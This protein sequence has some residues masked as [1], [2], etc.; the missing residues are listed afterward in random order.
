M[1]GIAGRFSFRQAG[2][3]VSLLPRMIGLLAHR[4]PDDSGCYE[5]NEAGLAQAR[6]SVID[7]I[8]GKQPM[9]SRDGSVWVAFNGEIFN[10]VELR[11]ELKRKGHVFQTQSDTEVLLRYLEE[12]GEECVQYLNGQFAV[13]IWD[14]RE[15]R[16]FL[17]R[18]RF[19]I[20]P[21]VLYAH[22]RSVSLRFGGEGASSYPEVS[23]ELDPEALDDI[24][25]FWF[26]VA[27]RTIFRNIQELPPGHSL[28]IQREPQNLAVL[29]YCI[30]PNDR[31]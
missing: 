2:E 1:C 9:S 3:S 22:S 21:F 27:P 30:Q 4:G 13:A 10:F 28:A 26:P 8:G 7:P 17:S 20:C 29:V 31:H 5:D 15:K 18:D 12:K 14:R 25:T 24:F 19:G 11:K 16:M 6:L 23:R